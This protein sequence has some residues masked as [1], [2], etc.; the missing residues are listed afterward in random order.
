MKL[1]NAHSDDLVTPKIKKTKQ[2]NIPHKKCFFPGK[3]FLR[4]IKNLFQLRKKYPNQSKRII[5]NSCRT[6][7]RLALPEP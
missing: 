1:L 4:E 6:D 2:K 7:E 5:V 3:L